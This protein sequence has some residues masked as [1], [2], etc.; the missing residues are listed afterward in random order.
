MEPK[1]PDTIWY[2]NSDITAKIKNSK[3]SIMS[4]NIRSLTMHLNQ[5]KNTVNEFPADIISISEIWKPSKDFVALPQYHPLI[6]KTRPQNKT[7]GGVGLYL[8]QK[9]TYQEHEEINNLKLKGI[10]IIGTK[11]KINKNST[12]NIIAA[13]RPPK[14]SAQDTIE[15]LDKILHTLG[16]EPSI[17]TG[18]MNINVATNN[19]MAR[20]YKEKLCEYNMTQTVKTSTRITNQSKSTID[21]VITNLTAVESIVTHLM[22]S[23]HQILISSLWS[24][25]AKKQ[26]PQSKTETKHKIDLEKTKQNIEKQDW[27]K[28]METH[29]NSE[30]DNTYESFHNIIQSCVVKKQL[31]NPKKVTNN[32]PFYNEE[33]KQM[34]IATD[35]KRKIFLKAQ[36]LENEKTFKEH[37]SKYNKALKA[38]KQAHYQ[39]KLQRAGKDSKKVWTVINQILNRG[40]SKTEKE[41]ITFNGE[42]KEDKNEIANIFSHHYQTAAVEKLKELQPKNNFR[43]YLYEHDKRNNKFQLNAIDNTQTWNIIKTLTSKTSSGFDEIS[44]KLVKSCASNLAP[45]LTLIINRCFE[46]GNFPKKLKLAKISPIHK[47]GEREPG[48]FRP[49]S[50]LPTFSKVIEKAAN[51]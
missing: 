14:S 21:H 38:A 4:L 11:I 40:K 1:K 23:D 29:M 50:E 25:K 16:N 47:K 26:K 42:E 49:I 35:K 45:P 30:L 10:E 34:K 8:S 31:K 24:K 27:K 5:L 12:V 43:E 51:I 22:L 15:D 18:D 33:L 19:A 2:N 41:T 37:R 39:E 13:Y 28:W 3:I 9:L 44:P 32:Q 20:Q 6:M 36:T 48:N 17:I 46:T 7:G